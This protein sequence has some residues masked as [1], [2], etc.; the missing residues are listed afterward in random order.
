MISPT[1]SNPVEVNVQINLTFNVTAHTITISLID[2][3]MDPQSIPQILSGVEIDFN[4][5]SAGTLG[6]TINS[7]S[8]TTFKID[9]NTGAPIN[10]TS[11]SSATWQVG[12]AG[13]TPG[14]GYGANTLALC[15]ICKFSG[16]GPAEL[17]IGGPN[18]TSGAYNTGGGL[19]TKPHQPYLLA[20][21]ATYATGPFAGTIST[22]TW[23]LSVPLLN[24][25]T[26]VSNIHFFF[27]SAY[28]FNQEV[29]LL[30]EPGPI[31][32]VMGGLLLIAGVWRRR[33]NAF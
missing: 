21:G 12:S 22:P 30:P 31:P 24:V 26:N 10:V 32:M 15:E 7:F 9:G 23:V 2:L 8:G 1:G 19:A 6:G 27:G 29:D 11:V 17:A 16:N 4:N 20:S 18:A 25:N 33:P 5:L 14:A 28:D 13:T 3:E